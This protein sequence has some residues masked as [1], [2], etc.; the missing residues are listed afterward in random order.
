MVKGKEHLC[1]KGH[2]NIWN[3]LIYEKNVKCGALGQDL[4]LLNARG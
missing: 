3:F 1:S 2:T 4:F